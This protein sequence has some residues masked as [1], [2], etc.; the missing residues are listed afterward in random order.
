MLP[1][2][3]Q[4]DAFGHFLYL[5]VSFTVQ[6]RTKDSVTSLAMKSPRSQD[7]KTCRLTTEEKEKFLD[8]NNKFRGMVQPT[9]ADME[10]LVSEKKMSIEILGPNG[11]LCAFRAGLLKR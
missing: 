5:V 7:F 4:R 9:A 8:E 10:F 3:R 2:S 1:R 11:N 6:F